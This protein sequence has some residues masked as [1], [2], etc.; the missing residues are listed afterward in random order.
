MTIQITSR[1]N[2]LRPKKA[3]EKLDIG[4]SSTWERVK[5]DP[6]FPKPFKLSSRVTVFFEDELDAYIMKLAD[7]SR[8]KVQV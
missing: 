3:A 2:L 7:Q 8:L 5:N 4:L 6:D 1:R